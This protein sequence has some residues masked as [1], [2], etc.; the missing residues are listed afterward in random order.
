MPLLV[1]GSCAAP[2]AVVVEE[3]SPA[4]ASQKEVNEE[5]PASEP[6]PAIVG[7]PDDG[8]RLP[9][10]LTLPGDHEFRAARPSRGGAASDSGA[11]IARPPSDP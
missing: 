1:I 9:D 6:E 11:V 5:E 8:I 4:L 7:P 10:M 3:E 2:Q